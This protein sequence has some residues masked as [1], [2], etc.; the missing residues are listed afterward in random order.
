[1]Q[2]GE[3]PADHVSKDSRQ[4]LGCN[5]GLAGLVDW[6]TLEKTISFKKFHDKNSSNLKITARWTKKMSQTSIK[7]PGKKITK[8]N[9]GS[10]SIYDLISPSCFFKNK[11]SQR[12]RCN[13]WKRSY[14]K[15]IGVRAGGAGGAA[16]PPVSKIFGQNAKNSGNKETINDGIEK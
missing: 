13:R 16:A 4:I 2:A 8:S 12:S 5:R 1:M 7:W 10:R 11:E 14:M 15:T 6:W 9:R 3:R